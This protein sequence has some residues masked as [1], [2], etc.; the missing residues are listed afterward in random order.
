MVVPPV[1]SDPLP[2]FFVCATA[3]VVAAAR[4][5]DVVSVAVCA[6]GRRAVDHVVVDDAVVAA[7]PAGVIACLDHA[8]PLA[9]LWSTD[10]PVG[11]G[12]VAE[13]ITGRVPRV[14]DDAAVSALVDAYA[15][16]AAAFAAR[17]VD[18]AVGAFVDNFCHA[19]CSPLMCRPPRPELMHAIVAACA[20]V[21]AVDVVV[22]VD[23][24]AP[25][26]VDAT[27][28]RALA[29]SLGQALGARA[30]RVIATVGTVRLLPLLV[31]DKGDATDGDGL[32]VDAVAFAA[33]ARVCAAG[34]AGAVS[35]A[36]LADRAKRLNLQGVLRMVLPAGLTDNGEDDGGAT[37]RLSG[38]DNGGNTR[39]SRRR[40][41]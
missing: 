41:P 34:V 13:S 7:W 20:A 22:V 31:R 27:A 5:G 21:C 28:G 25:G 33:G 12:L 18:V 29:R 15:R 40:S 26:G 1:A 14:V 30:R 6:E 9:A 37:E 3:A 10:R 23:D 4:A 2:R 24:L 36:R 11:S 38:V 16:A 32:F 17:G 35:D 8:G 39:G 19:C